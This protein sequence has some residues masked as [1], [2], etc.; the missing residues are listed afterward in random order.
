MGFAKMGADES[1]VSVFCF[2]IWLHIGQDV[3]NLAMCKS[4]TSIYKVILS[5]P[6]GRSSNKIMAPFISPMPGMLSIS[7]IDGQ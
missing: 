1:L 6:G 4:S 2:S 3:N 5:N 7:C